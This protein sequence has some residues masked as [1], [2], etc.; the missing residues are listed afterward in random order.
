MLS[1]PSKIRVS[2]AER[3]PKKQALGIPEKR[4]MRQGYV[5]ATASVILPLIEENK[6]EADRQGSHLLPVERALQEFQEG[7]I[8]PPGRATVSVPNFAAIVSFLQMS[9]MVAI[10]PRRLAL[11]A[12]A[13]APA[14]LAG[15]ALPMVAN[16]ETAYSHEYTSGFPPGFRPR[17]D[18]APDRSAVF[19]PL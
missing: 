5:G 6:S 4:E 7:K 2:R 13:N 9:D 11:W 12:A 10:A 16:R 14:F 1:S 18:F 3:F 19:R 8:I 17:E 15:S